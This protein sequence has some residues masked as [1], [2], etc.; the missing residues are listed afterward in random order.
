MKNL[1]LLPY[2]LGSESAKELSGLLGVKRLKLQGGL[3]NPQQG[4][5]ILNWG[6]GAAPSWMAKATNRAVKFL[7]KPEKVSIAGNKLSTLK[8]LK[9]AN[10]SVP[11]FTT[12]QN[13]AA[14]W[15][16]N[17]FTV[18]ERHSLRGNSGE[19]IR[20]VNTTDDSVENNITAAPL[21]TKFVPKTKEFRVHVFRGEIIDY[22]QKKKV[23]TEARDE[24]FN[25]YVSSIHQGWVFSRTDIDVLDSVKNI[26]LKAVSALGL[27]FGAVDIIFYDGRPFV[28]EV[29]TAPGLSGTT[30][31]KYA[32]AL[33]H[34]MG[35]G[36]LSPNVV[37]QVMNQTEEPVRAR[38][39][40]APALAGRTQQQAPAVA[41]RR[42]V[43]DAVVTANARHAMDDEMVTLTIDKATARKLRA[44]LS[45]I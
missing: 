4:H 33:R 19:G 16:R 2:K 35:F 30:L 22:V 25:K 43:R 44:L 9:D 28:L 21:Y 24:N 38:T 45:G 14:R 42:P 41:T 36:E 29:N 1:K 26:A 39:A 10:V 7:N 11:E 17:G 6:S 12:D 37:A 23:R 5:V 18:V 15:V 34:Y 13:V 40:A 31:V 3:Y 27:D 32:N 8:I 20:I